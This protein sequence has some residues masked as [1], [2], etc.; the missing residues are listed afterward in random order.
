MKGDFSR[1]TFDPAN[2][3]TSVRMQ[4]GRMQLDADWNE[5]MDILLHLLRAQA[6]AM[7]DYRAILDERIE[8]FP[9]SPT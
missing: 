9:G 2:N 4:Q 7:T 5:Q 3:F 8:R 6:D 1:S